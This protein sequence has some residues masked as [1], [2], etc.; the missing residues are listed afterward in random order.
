ML[1]ASLTAGK[2]LPESAHKVTTFFEIIFCKTK[3]DNKTHYLA[4]LNKSH[5]LKIL[6]PKSWPLFFILGLTSEEGSKLLKKY[7][8]TKV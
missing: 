1:P 8:V 6:G 4:L 3:V 2:L 5:L 7:N